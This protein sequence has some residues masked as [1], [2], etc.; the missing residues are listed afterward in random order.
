MKRFLLFLF[1]LSLLTG[2]TTHPTNQV[3]Q[4]TNALPPHIVVDGQYYWDAQLHEP[5]L[6]EDWQETGVVEDGYYNGDPYYVNYSDPIRLYIRHNDKYEM[7]IHDILW[8]KELLCYNGQ[9]YISLWGGGHGEELT[10]QYRGYSRQYLSNQSRWNAE[11]APD[12]VFLGTSEYTGKFT[13]PNCEL[14]SNTQIGPVYQDA[15]DPN[16]LFTPGTTVWSGGTKE[17]FDVYL[18]WA[19]APR[20]EPIRSA[21]ETQLSFSSIKQNGN[22]ISFTIQNTSDAE[23][24]YDSHL[25]LE[26]LQAGYWFSVPM[27]DGWAWTDEAYSLPPGEEQKITESLECYGVAKFHSPDPGQYRFVLH[28][29]WENSTPVDIAIP[30]TVS[31]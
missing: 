4:N 8:Q 25:Q 3:A 20:T 27:A 24:T 22:N 13:I 16:V 1:S 15:S 19:R 12:M 7:L 21:E 5:A 14:G 31:N 11:D 30:F 18:P 17:V 26:Q 2:C 23:F 9:L 29:Y 28:C 10:P 6:S